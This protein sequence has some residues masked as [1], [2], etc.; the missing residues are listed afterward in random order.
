MGW[1]YRKSI[2]AAPFKINFSKKGISYSFGMKGAR[3]NVS[4]RGTYVNL[5]AHGITYRQKISGPATPPAPVISPTPPTGSLTEIASAQVEQLT[6]T[7]SKT[8][9]TTLNEKCRQVSYVKRW[10]ILPLFLIV[11]ILLSTTMDRQQETVYVVYELV[12][13]IACFIPLIYW[14]KKLDKQR[15][16]MELH[17]DMD[18]KYQQVYQQFK[19]HF[20]SFSQS[21]RIWQY[22]NTQ[23]NA[24]YK[25]NA[26]AAA[27][28]KRNRINGV[29]PHKVPIP[30]FVTNVAI[31]CIRLHNMELFFFPERLLI[32]RGNT[33]AAVFYKNLHITSYVTR[34]I[35]SDILP[36]DAKVVDY[37]W[38]YVNKTGGPDKRFNDNRRLPICAYS[39][40]MFTSDTGIFEIISTSK[41]S[42]MDNFVGF[43][44]KI[45][46]LQANI[47]GCYQ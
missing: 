26:G 23:R 39:E 40:Y 47:D 4:S 13:C 7:D 5:S 34:F 8:F 15:F 38:Q 41:P 21:S 36:V 30:Y 29:S 2:G 37:T 27:L 24:D 33:F 19:T 20:A 1:S 6:D 14:L 11:L 3:V 32:K 22:L 12:I 42:S 44:S 9:V 18:D 10:G 16:G 45:G 28:I 35:E 25:R 17:Y 43:L 46:E 31:P